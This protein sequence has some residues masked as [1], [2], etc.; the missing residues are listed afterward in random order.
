MT[1]KVSCVFMFFFLIFFFY[2][3]L[4]CD[5]SE[6]VFVFIMV[7]MSNLSVEMVDENVALELCLKFSERVKAVRSEWYKVS[8]CGETPLG[9][10][11]GSCFGHT[12]CGIFIPKSDTVSCAETWYFHS[13]YNKGM[14]ALIS[15]KGKMCFNVRCNADHD[16]GYGLF[17]ASELVEV[18]RLMVSSKVCSTLTLVGRLVHFEGC[19]HRLNRHIGR[20]KVPVPIYGHSLKTLQMIERAK[21]LM[22]VDDVFARHQQCM[23]LKVEADAHF[24][25]DMC[26]STFCPSVYLVDYF[27]RSAADGSKKKKMFQTMFCSVFTERFE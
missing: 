12:Q 21:F 6:L 4:I 13:R 22:S 14:V 11:G 8:S 7:P 18:V 24:N 10:V 25:F 19:D 27:L 3:I 23:A 2:F 17:S 26:A 1:L 15:E 16:D 9:V 20:F 5:T